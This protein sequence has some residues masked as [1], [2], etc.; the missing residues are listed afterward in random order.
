VLL[1]GWG[2]SGGLNWFQAF[3]P[4]RR[5]FDVIAP[6]LRGHARGIR[7]F[8][9]FR[10]AE[11]ADDIAALLDKLGKGPA[12]IAGYSMGGP[13][14]QL[15][16]QR[17]PDK[18]AGLV[19]VATS[20]HPV[21]T[22]QGSR[23]FGGFMGSAALAGRI[24]EYTTWLPRRVASGAARLRDRPDRPGSLARWARAEMGRHS[25]RHLL[26]AGAEL[27]RYDAR[28]WI[29]NID[30]PT[31]VVV[32]ERDRAMPARF[33]LEMAT[34]IPDATIHRVDSGHLSCVSSDFGHVVLDACRDV[35]SR[36][37]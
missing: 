12:L 8:R 21:R 13:I 16:W 29:G 28:P 33:Q 3:A 19:M 5:H 9:P 18:V 11:C 26:E 36:L 20:A 7:S 2:A 17:H 10:L 15:L 24:A 37:R 32:T 6:D 4:L 1:H 23:V 25:I 34:G 22:E 14:A 30:V 31:A 35:V 27:G